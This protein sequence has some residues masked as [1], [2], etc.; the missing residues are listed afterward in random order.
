LIVAS[1]T[2]LTPAFCVTVL[3]L[4]LP[5]SVIVAVGPAKAGLTERIRAS[6]VD[7]ENIDFISVPS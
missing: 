2:A 6:A 1:V 4:L 7:A 3:T 5:A